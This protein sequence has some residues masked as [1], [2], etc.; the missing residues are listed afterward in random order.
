MTT[1]MIAR[2]RAT[3][4]QRES[5]T[6]RIV[7]ASAPPDAGTKAHVTTKRPARPRERRQAG[8]G[9]KSTQADLW[10]DKGPHV[11]RTVITWT[12]K[13]PHVRMHVRELHLSNCVG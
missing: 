8:H 3:S 4:N 6:T 12:A 5:S 13:L 9:D 2:R 1:G 11:F 7:R 10:P